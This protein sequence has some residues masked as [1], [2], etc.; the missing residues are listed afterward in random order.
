MPSS[1]SNGRYGFDNSTIVYSI[2]QTQGGGYAVG[3]IS[4]ASDRPS[5]GWMA[6]IGSATAQPSDSSPTPT[7][8]ELTPLVV[9]S[10]LTIATLLLTLAK[11]RTQKTF[12]QQ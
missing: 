11:K 12:T 8:P 7:V 5:E 9:A 3:G 6:L 2:I 10:A 4:G 1:T